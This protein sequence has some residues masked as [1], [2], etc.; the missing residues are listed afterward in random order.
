MTNSESEP[1]LSNRVAYSG[2]VRSS[3]RDLLHRADSVGRVHEVRDAVREIDRRLRLYPQFG[4][5][6]QDLN[7]AGETVW[8]GTVWPLVVHYILD[9]PRR[10]VIVIQPFLTYSRVGY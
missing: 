4:E 5:P 3:L 10:T 2:V 8:R 6:G 9:E 7:L 1:P